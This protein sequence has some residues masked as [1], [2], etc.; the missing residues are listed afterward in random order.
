MKGITNEGTQERRYYTR[1]CPFV[2]GAAMKSSEK[3]LESPAT[4]P[5]RI[6]RRQPALTVLI[7]G[8]S[9]DSSAII[10]RVDPNDHLDGTGTYPVTPVAAAPVFYE[11]EP[12][13]V[14]YVSA[15]RWTMF[16]FASQS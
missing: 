12:L 6:R 10:Q 3:A 4:R 8:Q 14:A 11:N 1:S 13:K 7:G 5:P 16:N 2:N 15:E 9:A